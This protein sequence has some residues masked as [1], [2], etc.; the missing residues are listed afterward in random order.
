VTSISRARRDATPLSWQL[1]AAAALAWVSVTAMLLPAG[2]CAASWLTGRGWVWPDAGGA[3]LACMKGLLE[4]HP[5]LDTAATRLSTSPPVALV[6]LLV[7]VAEVAWTT[8]SLLLLAA[9]WHTSGPGMCAG[10]AQRSEVEKVLGLSRMRHDR[11]VIRPDLYAKSS[12]NRSR[13]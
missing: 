3:L 4:G 8:V 5:T 12:A 2:Q 6:Y 1:P 11:K 13:S 10:M 7:I 9:W